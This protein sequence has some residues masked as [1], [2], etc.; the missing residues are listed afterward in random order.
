ML[1]IYPK[2]CSN[3]IPKHRKARVLQAWSERISK[4]YPKTVNASTPKVFQNDVAPKCAFDCFW[5]FRGPGPRV[6][7]SGSM[8]APR[9]L[10][11]ELK[12]VK[13]D[14][15]SHPKSI[16]IWHFIVFLYCLGSCERV[17]C[18]SPGEGGGGKNEVVPPFS[19][20]GRRWLRPRSANQKKRLTF[21]W[22]E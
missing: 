19:R 21:L 22:P 14:S 11:S 13:M 16:N 1:N 4:A 3:T 6:P 12:A 8:D 15:R 2:S 9:V 18:F 17:I 7:H 10:K 5:C 20:R